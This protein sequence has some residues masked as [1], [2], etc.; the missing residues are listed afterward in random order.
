MDI[1]EVTNEGGFDGLSSAWSP[2]LDAHDAGTIQSTF[3]WLRLW[4]DHYQANRELFILVAREGEQVVGI[5]PLMIE[6]SS[7]V[8]GLA[9]RRTI[10]FLGQG[11]SDYGDFIVPA[12]HDEIV[13]AF[14]GHLLKRRRRWDRI[15]LKDMKAA[16]RAAATA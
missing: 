16:W 7:A 15:E 9:S 1:V 5:A 4:W 12:R 13:A 11:A 10:G 3:D 14:V 8:K 6:T 2:L